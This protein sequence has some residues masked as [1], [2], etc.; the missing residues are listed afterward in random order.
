MS[1]MLRPLK[2]RT[3]IAVQV[4]VIGLMVGFTISY[5]TLVQ[6]RICG[7]IVL[8]DDAYRETPPATP[9]GLKMAREVNAYRHK[10]GC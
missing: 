4:V 3:F 1:P 7:L 9:T 8:M 2:I 5:V 6:R 10:I